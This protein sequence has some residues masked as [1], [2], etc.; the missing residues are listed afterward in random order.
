MTGCRE[1]DPRIGFS[2]FLLLQDSLAVDHSGDEDFFRS[3][4][5]N[6][7]IAVCQHFPNVLIVELRD[8]AAGT[9]ETC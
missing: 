5:I 7:P 2:L 4:S 8:F 9:R 1:Y 3:Q 6:N